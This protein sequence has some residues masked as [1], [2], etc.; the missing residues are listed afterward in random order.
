ME[1]GGWTRSYKLSL[2][3]VVLLIL[4]LFFWLNMLVYIL[5]KTSYLLDAFFA[6]TIIG[7]LVT[8]AC[9]AISALLA[10]FSFRVTRSRLS[11]VGLTGSIICLLLILLSVGRAY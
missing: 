1:E 3:S 10:V 8:L 5:F 4:P 11:K 7:Y 9:P 2:A 6:N